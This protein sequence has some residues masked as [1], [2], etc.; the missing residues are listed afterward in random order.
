MLAWRGANRKAP[1]RQSAKPA[2]QSMVSV[3]QFHLA[4]SFTLWPVLLNTDFAATTVPAKS[5]A[6]NR[7]TAKVN[8]LFLRG[9]VWLG[10]SG[11]RSPRLLVLAERRSD[12]G[13][14]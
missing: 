13:T 1:G 11:P 12:I 4:L 6:R 14:P 9:A 5:T 2:R 7:I 8:H 10:H 3:H